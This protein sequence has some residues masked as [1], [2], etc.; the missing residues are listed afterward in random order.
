M[1]CVRLLLLSESDGR[2][3]SS[4]AMRKLVPAGCSPVAS[5]EG[6]VRT[7]ALGGGSEAVGRMAAGWMAAVIAWS[8][9]GAF[10]GM[11]WL[12]GSLS[13]GESD[14][15]GSRADINVC[16]TAERL[17]SCTVHVC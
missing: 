16:Q 10:F 6:S 3:G 12:G 4:L 14:A 9:A 11:G 2:I 5:S 8:D 15:W 13:L 1:T 7:V 17:A